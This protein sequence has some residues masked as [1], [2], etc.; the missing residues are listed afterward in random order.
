MLLAAT[1][2]HAGF[3]L[4]VTA[5]VYPALSRAPD[6]RRFH[7]AHSRSITPV[8]AVVYIAVVTA[9]AWVVLE[10]VDEVGT[11]TALAGAALSLG[12][13]AFVAAPTHRSL[14]RARDERLLTR[15][16]VADLVRT[17]GAFLA[18]AGALLATL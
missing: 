13:T 18:L 9:S 3:Q 6:W 16:R 10:G 17:F 11:A 5:V 14:S 8:V 15:L 2:L 1:A 7:E 12:V 4:T